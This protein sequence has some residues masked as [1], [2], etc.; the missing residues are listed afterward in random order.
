MGHVELSALAQQL[1]GQ[2]DKPVKG[3]PAAISQRFSAHLNSLLA[4]PLGA[5][6]TH[7]CTFPTKHF[8]STE[9][10]F[11]RISTDER[12]HR[13]CNQDSARFPV[14]CPAIWSTLMELD[15]LKARSQP[16]AAVSRDLAATSDCAILSAA[17]QGTLSPTA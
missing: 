11:L 14:Q 10:V 15:L 2:H 7:A 1:A 17:M 8:A 16:T 3:S 4:D 9:Q 6:P 5:L 13:P 12:S